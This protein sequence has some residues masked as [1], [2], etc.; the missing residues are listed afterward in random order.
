VFVALD[1]QGKP[2][3]VPSVIAQGQSQRRRQK[4]AKIRRQ[5][6]LAHKQAIREHRDEVQREQVVAPP[7]EDEPQ[8]DEGFARRSH[9]RM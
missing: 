1:E 8:D 9:L 5:T 3:P 7:N 2:R 4:E 6:R